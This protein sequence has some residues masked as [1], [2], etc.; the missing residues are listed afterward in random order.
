M[1]AKVGSLY[2]ELVARGSIS[3]HNIEMRATLARAEALSEII[4]AVS[5]MVRRVGDA[6][7]GPVARRLAEAKVRRELDALTDRELA[8][9]GISRAEARTG[10]L[11]ELGRERE[12]LAARSVTPVAVN[13]NK[14]KAVQRAA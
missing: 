1:T 8:D 7:F 11:A 4:V 14:T 2:E 5:G 3:P 13:E 6:V 9:I 12:A 10:D